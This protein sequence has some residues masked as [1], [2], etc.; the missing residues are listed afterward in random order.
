MPEISE[1]AIEA[2]A[3]AIPD[4]VVRGWVAGRL[5]K[6]APRLVTVAGKKRVLSEL[7]KE[8]ERL[9]RERERERELGRKYWERYRRTGEARH[10]RLARAHWGRAGFLTRYIRG[11]VERLMIFVRRELAKEIKLEFIGID[12]DTGRE[13]YFDLAK[14][15]YVEIDKKGRVTYRSDEI[16]VDET[17]SVE[18]PE[19]HDAPLTCE[20]TTSFKVRR[21]EKKALDAIKRG[22]QA[23][24][25]RFLKAEPP[26]GFERVKGAF[27]WIE[28]SYDP[29][30][31][32]VE[33][34]IRV[35]PGTLEYP[36]AHAIIERSSSLYPDWRSYPAFGSLQVNLLTG[37]IIKLDYLKKLKSVRRGE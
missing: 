13:I 8:R 15:T 30:K 17:I 20:V 6:I 11:V 18:T 33:I 3:R 34:R 10:A 32:G 31:T 27:P 16:Q 21:L 37:R 35:K 19:G 28:S 2:Y 7:R 23:Q 24:L 25:D 29:L 12:A 5:R 26:P 4:R 9:E 36:K 22:V 1:R 14:K